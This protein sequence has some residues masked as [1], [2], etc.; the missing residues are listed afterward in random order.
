MERVFRGLKNAMDI[1]HGLLNGSKRPARYHPPLDASLQLGSTRSI[2]RWLALAWA[3][4]KLNV[5]PEIS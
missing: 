3:E 1:D 5:V 2:Q 4:E